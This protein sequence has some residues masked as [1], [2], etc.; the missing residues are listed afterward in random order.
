MTPGT[1]L[2]EIHRGEFLE[3]L[4]TGHWAAVRNG[5]VVAAGGDPTL[6]I[7][8][9]SSAKMLQALPLLESGAGAGLTQEQLALACA[10]HSGETRH[11]EKVTQWLGELG[12]DDTALMC[13]PQ[14]SRDREL[15]HA[16]IR[17]GTPVTRVFNNCSG[18]HTGFL[19][20][21]R[22][23]GAN[24]DYTDPE[25]PV[26]KAVRAAFEDCCGEESPGFGIDGC[27]APN[28]ATS[29]KGLARAM[30]LFATAGARD[31]ARSKAAQ[32]LTAAMIAYPELVSGKG[33]ACAALMH[34]ANGRA[35]VKTGA[36]GVFVAIIPDLELGIALKIADGATRASEVAMAALLARF[37]VIDRTHAMLSR[38]IRNWDGL[39]T[40]VERP[41]S[42]LVKETA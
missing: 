29:L 36:E 34:A 13:G 24:L 39:I 35:A 2:V 37:G 9:R 12:L 11:V 30:A 19:T 26:Q 10:S 14:A 40:G 25:H 6:T 21:A 27:S 5:E 23:F 17:E 22:H 8:P 1:P 28:F 42:G 38:E 16:M 33:R 15:R 4:H 41:V 32:R 18:K 20:L 7:L 3:S 31:D